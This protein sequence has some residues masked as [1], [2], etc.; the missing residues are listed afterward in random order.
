MDIPF[1]K[2]GSFINEANATPQQV[3]QKRA[4]LAAMM[5]R[6]G[7]AKYVGEGIGQLA[8]GIG[9]GRQQAR[10]N[11][12]EEAGRKSAVEMF[13]RLMGGMGGG[14]S[15]SSSGSYTPSGTWTP[16]P[17]A[18]KPTEEYMGKPDVASGGL[19][20]GLP[21]VGAGENDLD[22]G[23]AVMTPQEM[24]IEGAT[25][26]GLDPVDV[27]TAISYETGGKFDPLI[28]GPTTQWGTHEGLIQFGDPQGA[29]H[30]AVFDQG[31][32]AAW[33]SQLNPDSGAVWSY[34]D[35]TGVQPGMGLDQIYSAINAGG[36]NR[37]GASDA[38]NGGAPGT[39]ADKVAGM[40]PHREKAAAFLGGTW[41]PD[42]NAPQV[43][44]SAQNAPQG[45]GLGMAELHAA[46]AN[47]WL[48]ADPA[49][50]GVIQAEYA[51][52]SQM[53]DPMYQMQLDE[54]RLKLA[55]MQNPEAAAPEAFTE[56]MFTL[57]ALGIDPQSEEGRAYLMTGQ[58]PEAE[59]AN[60]P[61]GFQSL[62]MQARAA[63][64]EP[65]TPEYQ[66]FMANGGGS[67][68]P[69]AFTAL[70]MQARAAG[71]EP[72]TPEYQEFMA[73]RGAGLA[74]AATEKGRAQ[75]EAEIAAPGD[76]ASADVTLGYIDSIKNHPGRKAG[77]GGSAWLGNIPGTTA[78]EFQ[79]EVERLKAG[80]FL[81]AIQQLRGMGALSNAEGQTATAAVAALD[82]YGDEEGFLKRL[83]EYEA[84][85]KRGRE[86]A[87][88]RIKVE[89]DAAPATGADADGWTTL[90][91]G[92]KVRV[93]Q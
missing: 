6:F 24:L 56:R 72:G 37:M 2:S 59:G 1:F 68:T 10:L 90:P 67:G 79:I 7:S 31:P 33:R 55:E 66:E 4:L 5:P 91:N 13:E 49:M 28:Q 88:K 62:D 34:L 19:S 60:L 80:A 32:E 8:A 86:R 54:Q 15:A 57:N 40:G 43:T 51:R 42:P 52:Q 71:F 12:A 81:T 38:N 47:P 44:M 22:F 85:V 27:A 26:R 39:V 30:G 29:Q 11:R 25:R 92:V 75:A 35:S 74:A 87:A 9:L 41:T 20:F 17:P 48:M 83:A 78:K 45:G 16:A 89:E 3:A 21:Q 65:G 84:I 69:A 50:A 53:N 93:K 70:D 46:M 58:L 63:G 82:P 64:F 76:V 18:P 73:T 14:V 61:A 77:T 36:V 23:A